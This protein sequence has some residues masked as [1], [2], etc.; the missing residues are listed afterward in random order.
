MTICRSLGG[1]RV[2]RRWTSAVNE[3]PSGVL[4]KLKKGTRESNFTAAELDSCTSGNGGTEYGRGDSNLGRMGE[5]GA[6]L[7]Q[8]SFEGELVD[9]EQ[10]ALWR[11]Q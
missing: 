2:A 11:S 1:N 7:P 6:I 8:K 5:R 9:L 3:D 10:W 4:V